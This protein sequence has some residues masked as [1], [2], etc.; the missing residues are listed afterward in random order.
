MTFSLDEV[1]AWHHIYI[2]Y[3]YKQGQFGITVKDTFGTAVC[4]PLLFL[5]S[6]TSNPLNTRK[7][8]PYTTVLIQAKFE[9]PTQLQSENNYHLKDTAVFIDTIKL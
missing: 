8:S 6:L 1:I 2:D 7:S 5:Q 4:G 3:L 9:N